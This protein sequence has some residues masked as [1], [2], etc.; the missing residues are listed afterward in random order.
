VSVI[1]SGSGIAPELLDRVFDPLVTTKK[2]GTGLGLAV[3]AR[4]MEKHEGFV[5]C[6][7]RPGHTR[8]DLYLPAA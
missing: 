4:V 3:V 5:R 1:D 2:Q 7:S 6:E 8:F